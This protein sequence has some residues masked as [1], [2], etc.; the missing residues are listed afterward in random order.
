MAEEKAKH[1]HIEDVEEAAEKAAEEAAEKAG[2]SRPAVAN[3]L[4]LLA[5]PEE[6]K[7]IIMPYCQ[8]L[9]WAGMRI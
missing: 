4:R 2:K 1:I 7:L 9:R 8:P 3:A 6:V 5:L